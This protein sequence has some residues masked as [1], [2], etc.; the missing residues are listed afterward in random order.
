MPRSSESNSFPKPRFL[1]PERTYSSSRIRSR[2]VYLFAVLVL[3]VTVIAIHS[4]S[5]A[6]PSVASL[7]PSRHFNLHKP[8][9]S[10]K[11]PKNAEPEAVHIPGVRSKYAFATFLAGTTKELEYKDDNYLIATRILSYQLLHAD[12]TRSRDR[13][14]PFIVAVTDRVK[15]PA[16]E[17]LRKDGATVIEVPGLKADWLGPT[18]ESWEHVMTKLRLWELVDFE[19]IAFVDADTI[20]T[21]PLDD[22]FADPAV[23]ERLT[24]VKIGS[25]I[26]NVQNNLPSS[27][28]F[29]GNAEQQHEHHF[30]PT[31]EG[32]DWPNKAYLNAGFFVMKPDLALLQHYIKVLNT[33]NSFDSSLPE[34][35]LL[36]M[37]HDWKGAMPWQQLNT[38]LNIHYPKMADIDGGAH[39]VHEKWWMG[40]GNVE[41]ELAAWMRAW[42]WRMEGYFEDMDQRQ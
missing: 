23:E 22:I 17:R 24:T 21:E 7:A 10:D 12:E 2:A 16:R 9:Q 30:P 3:V 29:A 18:I 6:L 39:S 4:Y 14:I 25:N 36:N 27:Y 5:Y 11:R 8:P 15:E 32:R 35:N 34:Q 13:N 41:D 37:V 1:S 38:T 26:G 19:R 33:A 40:K 20:L 31:E 42:R 28:V